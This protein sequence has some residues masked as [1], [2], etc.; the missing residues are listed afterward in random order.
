MATEIRQRILT[1]HAGS[2]P[3]PKRLQDLHTRRFGGEPVDAADLQAQVDTAVADVVARQAR[4]GIDIGNDGE[5]PRES[6]FTFVQHRM[7]GFGGRSARP[8]M[9][10]ITR[11]P[12]FFEILT[13]MY[14]SDRV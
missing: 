2:L 10:D 7:T 12:G 3:R 1:T 6:F 11:Y 9:A 4:A 13:R 5:A 14:P 8:S